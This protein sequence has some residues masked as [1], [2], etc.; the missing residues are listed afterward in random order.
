MPDNNPSTPRVLSFKESLYAFTNEQCNNAMDKSITKS[1][2]DVLKRELRLF[3]QTG[4]RGIYLTLI[5]KALLTITAT[6]V[7]SERSFSTAGRMKNKIR[8]KMGDDLLN[9][10]TILNRYFKNI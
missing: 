3:D 5:Y 4:Q 9:N 1:P 7:E 8:S 6:S 2:E 10:L